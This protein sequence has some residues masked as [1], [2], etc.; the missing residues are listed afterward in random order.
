M[1]VADR[2]EPLLDRGREGLTL[3]GHE[4]RSQFCGDT[5]IVDCLV[6]LTWGNVEDVAGLQRCRRTT[7]VLEGYRALQDER[8]HLGGVSVP[9]LG[10]TGR[11]FDQ[12]H[13]SLSI[14]N[15]HLVL[16]DDGPFDDWGRLGDEVSGCRQDEGN[17]RE[18]AG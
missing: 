16:Q 6:N 2:S 11:Q 7:V 14:G 15:G 5:A 12:S 17:D 8:E 9:S 3:V 18:R 10:G 1:T 13:D 4:D